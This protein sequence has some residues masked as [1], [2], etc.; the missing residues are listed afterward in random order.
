LASTEETIKARQEA[1]AAFLA[2]CMPRKI[3]A[4]AQNGKTYA[5]GTPMTFTVPIVPGW[6][7]KIFVRY[8]L[9]VTA[10]V[11]GSNTVVV[12]KGAPYN[13]FQRVRVDFGGTERRNHHP[14]FC[15]LFAQT[16][17]HDGTSLAYGGP[18]DAGYHDSVYKAPAAAN[19]ANNWVGTIE[20]P[21]QF[22]HDSTVGLL[23]MGASAS[24]ITVT[25]E[26][27]SSFIGTD[28]FLNPL[29]K[30]AGSPTATVTGTI[31]VI[32]EYLYGQSTHA[33]GIK[34]P[35]PYIGSFATCSL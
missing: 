14:Y 30:T 6:A 23:P 12:S 31:E 17:E 19:G 2:N 21:L 34:V 22:Q 8:N 26:C 3:R 28:P 35:T 9:T 16:D 7:R 29:V 24:P 13:I 10:T 11:D 27:V 33:P 4:N 32:V 1:N 25:L 5:V 15:K 18:Y 20:I